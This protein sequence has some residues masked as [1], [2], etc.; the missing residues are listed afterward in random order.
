MSNEIVTVSLHLVPV[1]CP[2]LSSNPDHSE[3]TISELVVTRGRDN[4]LPVCSFTIGAEDLAPFENGD[5]ELVAVYEPPEIQMWFRIEFRQDA[6][7]LRAS[8]KMH[9]AKQV[10]CEFF[11]PGHACVSFIE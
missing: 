11:A 9:E 8:S 5:V 10:G 4:F 3:Q 6:L 1:S 2:S 7:H